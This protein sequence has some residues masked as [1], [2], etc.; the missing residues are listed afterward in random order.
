MAVKISFVIIMHP[1]PNLVAAQTYFLSEIHSKPGRK[2]L[3][4]IGVE[5]ITAD[6]PVK[7]PFRWPGAQIPR[8]SYSRAILS[9][10]GFLRYWEFITGITW[11]PQL[12]F[13]NRG[14]H[15]FQRIGN[16]IPSILSEETEFP[17]YSF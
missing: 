7:Q 17:L 3:L 8:L 14:Q 10:R 13:I 16:I 4:L 15:H 1:L 2:R 6:I 11:R 12:F 9:Q 5:T